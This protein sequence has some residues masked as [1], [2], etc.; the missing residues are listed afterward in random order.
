MAITGELRKALEVSELTFEELRAFEMGLQYLTK[1]EQSDFVLMITENPEL[2]YTTYINY[3]AKLHAANSSPE[4][5]E[6]AIEKEI[7]E[8]DG[9]MERRRVGDELF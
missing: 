6:K 9:L 5:W 3:K 4:E 1:K 8:L 2:I 7:E